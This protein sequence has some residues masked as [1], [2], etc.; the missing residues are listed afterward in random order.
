MY[1]NALLSGTNG[2]WYPV[3]GPSKPFSSFSDYAH[4]LYGMALTNPNQVGK[5][6]DSIIYAYHFG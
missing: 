6:L 1:L 2:I 4:Y 5:E 3:V